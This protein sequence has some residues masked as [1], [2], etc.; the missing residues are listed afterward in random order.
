MGLLEVRMSAGMGEKGA[1]VFDDHMFLNSECIEKLIQKYWMVYQD[2]YQIQIFYMGTR[3][4]FYIIGACEYEGC[5]KVEM[6]RW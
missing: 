1:S 6:L 5:E 4:C 2:I 3:W